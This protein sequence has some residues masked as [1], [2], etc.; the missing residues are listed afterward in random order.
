MCREP[1]RQGI[2][3]PSSQTNLS[4]RAHGSLA[5][6]ARGERVLGM[7]Q[8]NHG[9]W[10]MESRKEG[11]IIVKKESLFSDI[12]DFLLQILGKQVISAQEIVGGGM[13]NFALKNFGETG[14]YERFS[15][16]EC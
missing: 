12:K 2:P 14:F 8:A 11:T 6:R 10:A 4:P 15:L 7:G 5:P 1:L 16:L 9:R 13:R 3:R